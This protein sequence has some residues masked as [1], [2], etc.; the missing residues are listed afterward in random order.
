MVKPI[1]LYA[2]DFW[3]CLKLDYN[4]PIDNSH[5]RFCKDLLG[6]QKQTSNTGVLLEL[7][8]LPITQFAKKNC[9]KN[10]RRIHIQKKANP[11]LLASHR[12]SLLNKL[13]WTDS[14]Y[15]CLNG[16]GVQVPHR[17]KQLLENVSWERL[18]DIFYQNSFAEVN[19]GGKLRTY[20]L[21]KTEI[22]R[23]GYLDKIGN[24]NKRRILTKI[25]LSNHTLMIEKGRHKG[26]NKEERTCP[27]CAGD[28][29]EDEYHFIFECPTFMI[30]R[31]ELFDKVCL[32]FP[33]FHNL[34]PTEK[35][36]I[37]LDQEE[38]AY[39]CCT[40]LER[41]FFVREFPINKPKNNM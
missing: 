24:Y 17:G 27:F 18:T 41:A 2:S 20:A 36:K 22:G 1:L 9:I 13:I 31:N 34:S 21:L 6:V 12:E 3:G 7:S 15:T 8:R 5:M 28:K 19:N 35:L 38:T 4:N 29:V 11:L 14:V 37:V 16:I 10:W 33:N 23:A 26:L 25:R 39:K 30:P 40:F 32:S